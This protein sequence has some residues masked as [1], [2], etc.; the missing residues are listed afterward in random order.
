MKL[1]IAQFV[2]YMNDYGFSDYIRE[3]VIITNSTADDNGVVYE[4]GESVLCSGEA[5]YTFMGNDPEFDENEP[6]TANAVSENIEIM[7][8][9]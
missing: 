9:L 6:L 8:G 1:T 5:I 3:S 7:N 4:A 2:E